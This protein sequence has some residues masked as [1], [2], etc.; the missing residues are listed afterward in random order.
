MVRHDYLDG[1]RRQR[2]QARNRA[3]DLL[4]IQ[5]AA[6]SRHKRTGAVQPDHRHLGVYEGGFQ[7]RADPSAIAAERIQDAPCQVEGRDVVIT[8]HDQ[9]RKRQTVE[10]RGG[11]LEL[12]APRALRQVP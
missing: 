4:V 10:K 3:I 9:F 7:V 5:S 2:S 12:A 8:G 11:V 6:A 1:S